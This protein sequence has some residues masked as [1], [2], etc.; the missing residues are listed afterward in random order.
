MLIVTISIM[1]IRR[2]DLN[3]LRTLDAMLE[4]RS[5]SAAGRRLGS[6]QPAVSAALAKLRIAFRDELFVRTGNGMQPTSTALALAEPLRRILEAID[7]DLLRVTSFDPATSTRRFTLSTSDIGE[8]VFLPRL[9]DLLHRE[10]PHATARALAV[11]HARLE[12]AMERGEVDIAIGYFPDLTGPNIRSVALFEHPFVCLV[13]AGH[14][15]IGDTLSME[16]FLS[17][18][19]LVVNQDGRS[20]EIFERLMA[21][22]RL[23]RRIMLHLPHFMSV[24]LLVASTD[25]ISTVPLTLA[26]TSMNTPGLRYLAPPL[27]IPR[28]PLR[29]FWHR[30]MANEP[31]IT[32]LRERLRIELADRDP[33]PDTLLDRATGLATA[34]AST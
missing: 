13:R 10:A 23:K 20:Q 30:R 27:P 17:A 4:T 18:D 22:R 32:W 31:A 3:L 16:Q 34:P 25:L 24:P 7:R 14:P 9:I 26:I 21:E 5:V 1:D 19:H 12:E 15:T 11:P 2:L 33:Y 29:L 6:S 8:L 28:I